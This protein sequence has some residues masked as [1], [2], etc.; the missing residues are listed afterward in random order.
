MQ[1]NITMKTRYKQIIYLF[2]TMIVF[3]SCDSALVSS[4]KETPYSGDLTIEDV[5]EK[6]GYCK[7]MEWSEIENEKYGKLAHFECEIIDGYYFEG[8]EYLVYNFK[9]VNDTVDFFNSYNMNKDKKRLGGIMSK[10][11]SEMIMDSMV[12][13]INTKD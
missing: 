11:R 3:T 10:T 5:F 1:K 7:S 6:S 2:I 12:L 4:V 9:S 8:R 13:M